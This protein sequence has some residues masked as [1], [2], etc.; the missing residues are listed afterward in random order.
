MPLLSVV[1]SVQRRATGRLP[2]HPTTP[3]GSMA[4]TGSC[5]GPNGDAA[6]EAV[7][8]LNAL[9][10]SRKGASTH[11]RRLPFRSSKALITQR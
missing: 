4:N 2:T 9:P 6:T 5:R 7:S 8:A 10:S 11:S 1:L 3:T